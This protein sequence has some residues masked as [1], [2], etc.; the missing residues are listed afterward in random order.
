MRWD[1]VL[2]GDAPT[3]T[4]TDPARTLRFAHFEGNTYV[5]LYPDG[6]PAAISFK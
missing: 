6:M 2:D 1:V 5:A 4:L 3:I